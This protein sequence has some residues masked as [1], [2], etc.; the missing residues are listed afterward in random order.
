M[1]DAVHFLT[2]VGRLVAGDLYKPQTTDAEGRPLVIKNGPNAGQPRV[3]FFFALAIEKTNADYAQLYQTIFGKARTD[4]PTLFDAAG[5]CTNP[6]FAFKIVDGDSQVPNAKGNKPCDREGYAGH[7]VLHFS[8][9]YAPKVYSAGG[10]EQLTTPD[11]VK[12][13]YYV[14]VAG[15]VVGN[16]SMQQPGVFLNHSMVEMIGYGA[17]IQVGPDA[18]A[19]FGGTPAAAMPAGVSQ[20]PL[21]PTTP[22]P[23]HPGAQPATAAPLTP[24]TPAAPVAGG[25]PAPVAPATDFLNGGAPAAPVAP[26]P[27]APV[28]PVAERS[29][30]YEGKVYTESALRAANWS[31]AAIN[32]LPQA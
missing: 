6:K 20:T 1:A 30:Q 27:V 3:D 12:R 5:N 9:G 24:A 4:F 16:G 18:N 2:P 13:G 31:D 19:L 15:S 23:A 32:A 11:A 10:Q 17:E 29:F 7:W 25:A 21:A 26:A 8:G 22:P 28:A 14:R